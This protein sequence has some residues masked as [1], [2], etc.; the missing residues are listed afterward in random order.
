MRFSVW[1][2]CRGNHQP[3]TLGHHSHLGKR[4]AAF[5][6]L[7]TTTTAP[8]FP[9]TNKLAGD[10][11]WDRPPSAA[12]LTLPLFLEFP[13]WPRPAPKQGLAPI[14]SS[15]GSPAGSQCHEHSSTTQQTSDSNHVVLTAPVLTAPSHPGE[16]A[17]APAPC[18]SFLEGLKKCLQALRDGAVLK[19]QPTKNEEQYCCWIRKIHNPA[20]ANQ[21]WKNISASAWSIF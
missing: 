1:Q 7:F 2:L 21:P 11:T 17:P 16:R 4:A 18:F 9:L 12:F 20:K 8:C 10:D 3:E 14:Y 19:M 13:P 6:M 5:L 15:T